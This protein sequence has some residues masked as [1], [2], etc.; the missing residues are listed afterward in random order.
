MSRF[1]LIL[2]A[3][4][5]LCAAVPA[6]AAPQA[7]D[8]ARMAAAEK[9]LQAMHYD[10]LIDRTIDSVVAEV[11]RSIDRDINAGLDQPLPPEIVGKIKQLAEAHMRQTFATRRA[12]L[13]RGTLLIYMKHFTAP[14][15]EHLAQLQ[16]DPVMAKMQTETPQIAAETM[17]LSQGLMNDG[18]AEL[19][20]Q[21][22][23]LVEDYLKTKAAS[24]TS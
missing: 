2:L 21:V 5:A 8:P 18:D 19:R 4:A 23:A 22:K 1:R 9:L 3:G 14:E 11:Q 6:S 17:A 15:L 12:D 10:S 16:A 13:K 7:A 20:A 24:P